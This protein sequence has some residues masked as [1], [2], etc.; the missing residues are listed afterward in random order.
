MSAKF[1]KPVVMQD[2]N[3][4]SSTISEPAS[5]ETAWV[6]MT[7]YTSGQEVIRTSTHMIYKANLNHS[8]GTLPENDIVNWT[9]LRAT[10]RWRMFDNRVGTFSSQ[11]SGPLTVVFK[12]GSTSGLALLELQGTTLRVKV[13]TETG[14][15][16]VYDN[17]INLDDTYV[18]YFYDWFFNE[19]VS[20]TD[21]VLNNLPG[22]YPNCE[23]EVTLTGSGELRI[24][25]LKS[26][27]AENI[28]LTQYGATV[29]IRDFS[30]KETNAFG[31]TTVVQRGFTKKNNYQVWV[32]KSAFNR[33][34]RKLSEVRATPCI[35][36]GVDQIGFEPTIV[37]G[38]FKDFSIDIAYPSYHICT[39]EVEGLL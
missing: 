29:G 37:Y 21:V 8:S 32:E 26:G 39:L 18:N 13:K 1:I 3:L 22:Q 31:E 4:V 9:P 38:F 34:Y 28:G 25:V 7:A 15:T 12:P 30:I 5:G 14:G 2:S 33:V 36:I 35:Y 11:S 10:N 19:Y 23:I 16:I 17:T 27:I 20:R 6:A 24:G